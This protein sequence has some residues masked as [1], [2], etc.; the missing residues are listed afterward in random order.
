MT[1]VE[2]LFLILKIVL[3]LTPLNL[4]AVLILMERRGAAFIQD[5][6][7]PARAAIVIPGVNLRLRGFGLIHN[8][9]DGVKLFFKESILPPFVNKWFYL[10]APAIPLFTA[11][12]TPGLIPWFGP[13]SVE[14]AHGVIK[15][16]WFDANSGILALFAVGSLSVYG[17]VLGSWASN[18]KYSLLGG[19]RASAMM[20]SYEVSMGLSVLG[21]FLLVGSFSLTQAVEWQSQHTWGVFVQPVGFLLFLVAM[22]AETNRNPFDV[23]EGE[24]ELVAGFHTEFASMRFGLF[25]TGEYVHVII[26]SALLA[27]LYFG[28]YDLLPFGCLHDGDFLMR[29][30]GAV[31]GALLAI[32]ALLLFGFSWLI[33]GRQR[34]YAAMAA[35]DKAA[36]TREYGFYRTLFTVG[37]L[38]AAALAVLCFLKVHPVPVSM[39]GG[40]A[41]WTLR[42][43]LGLVAVQFGTLVA[44]TLCFC[45]LFVWV[46]WTL[47]RFRY[48]QIMSLGWK[49]LLNIALVNLLV[50]AVIAKLVR[51]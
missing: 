14:G 38:L 6:P 37:G 20:I 11:L 44:K 8:L 22:F 17:I 21:L 31:L 29:H 24:S 4:V 33:R 15:G 10:V 28:G 40:H 9:T 32:K 30:L 7:G 16:S 35:S 12:I 18:S 45:W 50:T 5:R 39:A 43:S 48:D 27:T 19:M 47:P 25:M 51:G 41:V 36:R 46:R 2:I 13:V 23:A 3:V 42:A 1:N 26:A 49:W 34:N